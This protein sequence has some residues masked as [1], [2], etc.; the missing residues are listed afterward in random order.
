MQKK[1][2]MRWFLAAE[3]ILFAGFYYFGARGVKA[4][5]ELQK[6]NAVITARLEKVHNEIDHL[7][8][9]IVARAQEPYFVEK[10]AREELHM[11][12]RD[13]QIFIVE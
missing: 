4:V 3:I 10:I 5:Q 2:V 7:K 12:H 8:K 9:D 11:A 13:D 6:E 1:K